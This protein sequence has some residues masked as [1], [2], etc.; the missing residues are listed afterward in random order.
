MDSRSLR[1][2]LRR[3]LVGPRLTALRAG[4]PAAAAAFVVAAAS[5]TLYLATSEPGVYFPLDTVVVAVVASAVY[6]ARY[7][8]LAVCVGIGVAAFAGSQVGFHAVHGDEAVFRVLA[9]FARQPEPVALGAVFGAVGGVVG[10]LL[11]HAHRVRRRR[12]A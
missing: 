12:V 5:T 7:R 2:R 11:G 1:S 6:A 9:R 3:L 4:V 8:A 10:G